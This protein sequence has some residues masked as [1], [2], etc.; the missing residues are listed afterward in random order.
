MASQHRDLVLVF[1]AW[2]TRKLRPGNQPISAS[3]TAA[4]NHSTGSG[5]HSQWFDCIKNRERHGWLGWQCQQETS[6]PTV[7]SI[8]DEGPD[9]YPATTSPDHLLS[10]GY[11]GGPV[12][13]ALT[14]EEIAPIDAC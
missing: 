13:L 8:L 5:E 6:C 11:S 7:K 10:P 2:Q 3:G 14:P 1:R 4:L 12:Y 9:M